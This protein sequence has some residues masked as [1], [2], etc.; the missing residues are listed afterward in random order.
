VAAID[1]ECAD[2][3]SLTMQ[4]LDGQPL[5]TA[6]PGQYV[7]LR[8]PRTPG[9]T[10]LFRSY[11]L[12]GPA[13]MERYRISV[14]IEPKRCCRIP[15]EDCSGPIWLRGGVEL[16]SA[17]GHQYERRNNMTICRCGESKSKPFCD[18]LPLG[19]LTSMRLSTRLCLG[20]A[21]A[22]DKSSF[23]MDCNQRVRAGGNPHPAARSEK[24]DQVVTVNAP[25]PRNSSRSR[26][27]AFRARTPN[28]AWARRAVGEGVKSCPRAG[29]NA[30]AISSRMALTALPTL[31]GK[32]I[33]G[34]LGDFDS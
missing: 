22:R 10:P 12:S 4:S 9:D 2:V 23:G 20:S 6:L 27:A 29:Y 24:V 26:R 8:L 17:D 15:V 30:A 19:D 5:P 25:K 1:E 3:L 18:G 7:V 31:P 11:S 33:G 16:T 14:K 13:S 34:P 28:R 32:P 21:S